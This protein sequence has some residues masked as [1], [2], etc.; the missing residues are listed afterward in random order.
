MFTQKFYEETIAFQFYFA[1]GV[2]YG[3]ES[4]KSSKP[5]QPIPCVKREN[6]PLAIALFHGATFSVLKQFDS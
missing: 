4:S 1:R 6:S 5:H 3:E 2:V